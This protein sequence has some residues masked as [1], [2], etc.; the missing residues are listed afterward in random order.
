ME[1]A[2]A[3]FD[4]KQN[5]NDSQDPGRERLTWNRQFMLLAQG[6]AETRC[7][8]V[9]KGA[10]TPCDVVDMFLKFVNKLK[11]PTLANSYTVYSDRN[12]RKKS[13]PRA[14]TLTPQTL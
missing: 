6:C 12:F 8:F 2:G 4:C 11:L 14:Q 5:F 1:F 9:W 10:L 7:D 13:R 3:G